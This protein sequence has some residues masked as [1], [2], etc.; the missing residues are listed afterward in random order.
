MRSC[1]VLKVMYTELKSIHWKKLFKIAKIKMKLF[2]I[3]LLSL[4]FIFPTKTQ[5]SR[6]HKYNSV[7]ESFAS[8]EIDALKTLEA[9]DLSIHNYSIGLNNTAKIFCA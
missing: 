1:A 4:C 5:A 6:T 3:L 7:C 9:L 2:S 8:G